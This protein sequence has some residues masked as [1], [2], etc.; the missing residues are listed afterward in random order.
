MRFRNLCNAEERFFLEVPISLE[1]LEMFSFSSV[2][3]L[4]ERAWQWCWGS[5]CMIAKIK[6]KLKRANR[7]VVV[8]AIVILHHASA[9]LPQPFFLPS[10]ATGASACL[11]LSIPAPALTVG[12]VLALRDGEQA[13]LLLLLLRCSSISHPWQQKMA[14]CVQRSQVWKEKRMCWDH[15]VLQLPLKGRSP[16]LCGTGPWSLV[17]WGQPVDWVS[18]PWALIHHQNLPIKQG[19]NA[20]LL[21]WMVRLV[22]CLIS[23]WRQWSRKAKLGHNRVWDSGEGNES[24][25]SDL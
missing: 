20:A 25:C 6:N 9:C 23:W 14:T 8:S 24:S 13:V 3:V 21:L 11:Q 22:V 17:K 18:C 12:V 5:K 7:S 10:C 1:K 2:N 19:G 16:P 4:A 15:P